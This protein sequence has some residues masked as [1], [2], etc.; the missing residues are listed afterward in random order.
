M[1]RKKR[2]RLKKIAWSLILIL[3][4]FSFYLE[5]PLVIKNYFKPKT[6]E[7]DKQKPKVIEPKLSIINLESN[8]RPLAIMIDNHIN[9][10]EHSGLQDAYLIYE[11]VVEGGITRFLAL[12]K[13]QD[14]K[15]IGPVRSGRHYYL[16][17]A[18]ENNAIY[19]HYGHSPKTLT[20]INIL[21]A[22]NID[23]MFYGTPFNR[24]KSLNSPHNVFT[25]IE[26]LEAGITK[27]QYDY[28]NFNKPLLN[29]SIKE[30]NLDENNI[31]NNI[32]IYYNYDYY[33]SYQ[34]DELNKKYQRSMRGKAHLDKETKKQ[35]TA[36]NII[37]YKV[38][39]FPLSLADGGGLN[40]Q[41]L[42]NI[43]NGEGYYITN[44]YAVPITWEKSSRKSPTIYKDKQGNLLKVNDGNTFIHLQPIN[45]NLSIN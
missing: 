4:G 17:Y 29:Y 36:K 18:L 20:D 13:D 32:K 34:Y 26:K 7:T 8:K 41:N 40:R 5:L 12:F 38:K 35:Y 31:A 25:N 27:K 1:K 9:V 6:N 28:H 16:D 42:D 19:I 43:G 22:D 37:I 39:N 30:V 15:L 2:P 45:Q 44:G 24:D 11:I 14:T 33:V 23:G 21:K 10:K 3:I